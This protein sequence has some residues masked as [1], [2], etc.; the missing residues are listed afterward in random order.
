M[1]RETPHHLEVAAISS[2]SEAITALV[3]SREFERLGSC[4]ERKRL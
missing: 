4:F 1:D 3:D 2:V